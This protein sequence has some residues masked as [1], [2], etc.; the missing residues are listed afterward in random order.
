MKM[1]QLDFEVSPTLGRTMTKL[2]NEGLKNPP[3]RKRIP[4]TEI[5]CAEH[6][7]QKSTVE[8]MSHP[9]NSGIKEVFR[10]AVGDAAVK[11]GRCKIV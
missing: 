7:V 9:Y 1:D 8:H 5:A 10:A 2:L 6:L 3:E 11:G 4:G